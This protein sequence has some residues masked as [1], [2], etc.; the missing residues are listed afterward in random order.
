[1]IRESDIQW[2]VLEV[3][4]HPEAA[5]RII[6]ELGK[7][8][9]EL[10][11][12]NERLRGELLRLR[13]HAPAPGRD[14][15]VETLQ[16]K[17]ETLQ[18][19]LQRQ[20]PT[21]AFLVLLSESLQAVR[22]P[23]SH[24]QELAAEERPVLN[25]RAMLTLHSAVWARPGDELLVLTNQGRGFRRLLADVAPL[26]DTARW[27]SAPEAG[28][29]PGERPTVALTT[30]TP[31]RFWTVVTRRGYVQRLVRVACDQKIARGDPLLKSPFR[32]D[33]PTAIV[34]GDTSDILILT[35]WGKAV[36][37]AQRVIE[38][39]GSTALDLEPDDQVVA[40][41][42]LGSSTAPDPTEML[43]VT[44]SGYAMRR[45]STDVPTRTS[46][47]GAGKALIQAHDVLAAFH[48]APASHTAAPQALREP[49]HALREPPHALREPPHALREP[50]LV[51]MT[52]SGNLVFVPTM[53]IPLHE[54]LGK[55]TLLHDLS[56]D[57]AIAVTLVR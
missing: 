55:G 30:T 39:R 29:E 28:L 25:A 8:L 42:A 11:A 54:R 45:N 46:A 3:N 13:H 22:V 21:D 38:T 1:M 19:I 53:D 51:F 17:V 44:A 32:N 48:R 37:F 4:K 31:P 35:R 43:I 24:A 36:R 5:P 12:E 57:P 23:L 7:R 16:R 6:E 10:D 2:W 14:T 27:P 34:S 47:G 9:V 52:Y 18:D 33:A 20:E 50:E 56:R 26:G 40:A 41:M 49:P 15:R